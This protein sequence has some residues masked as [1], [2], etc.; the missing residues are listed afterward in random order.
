MKIYKQQNV[1]DA[2]LDRIRY[3]FD[4]FENI[5]VSFSGGKDSTVVLNLAMMVAKEKN[6]LPVKVLF[7]DQEAEWSAVIDYVRTVMY[8]PLV[9]PWWMQIPLRLYN[10]TSTTENW[11][12]C[13]NPDDQDKWVHP[14]DPISKKINR[15][16][17][18]RFVKLFEKIVATEFP[19]KKTAYLAGMRT[20]ESHGREMGL[21]GGLT[22]KSITYGTQLSKRLQHYTFYPIYDWCLQD[23]WKAIHDNKWPYCSVYD[24][25]YSYGIAPR[26]MRVSNV[27]H[28]TAVRTLFMLQE[29]DPVVW[30]R[31]TKRI[32]GINT[33]GQLKSAS[34][35]TPKTLP[36]MFTDW[37]EYRDYLLEN[38]C[39]DD[40]I[41]QDF[42]KKF[43]AGDTIYQHQLIRDAFS[44]V[45]I[46]AILVN[47]S[48]AKLANFRVDPEV[49]AY[50][51]FMEGKIHE[52][53]VINP[54]ILNA[55][56]G[57]DH[58]WNTK[59]RLSGSQ[60]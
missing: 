51:R 53:N 28:E 20:E 39:T 33:A 10:S 24:A 54:Y 32:A 11:L 57:D 15:Y 49:N 3:L 17:S 7:I 36:Y 9:E 8:N 4:E 56:K 1:F 21:T 25:F 41:K 43:A 40:N 5:I 58:V 45:C 27:H 59:K 13:W 30:E 46:T 44:K 37:T 12:H 48:G 18:D 23:V 6:R 42:S 26:D 52:K 22:Y 50:R 38:L 29:L 16:G 34:I 14:Q 55:L 19:D 60:R 2:A 47:D 35:T 31:L